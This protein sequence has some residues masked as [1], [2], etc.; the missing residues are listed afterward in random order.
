MCTIDFP[1]SGQIGWYAVA[2]MIEDFSSRLSTQAL[3]SVPL[4][5]LVN[6]YTN[7]T[8]CGNNPTF[9]DITRVDGSC[10]GVPLNGTFFEPIIAYSGGETFRLV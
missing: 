6:V 9:V 8:K 5:F 1:S 3:S 7:S 2:V 4:Q 10:V